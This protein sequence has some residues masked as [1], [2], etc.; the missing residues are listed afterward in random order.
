M[1][2]IKTVSDL[3]DL[4]MA[5]MVEVGKEIGRS[6]GFSLDL[7]ERGPMKLNNRRLP[8]NSYVVA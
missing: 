8:S 2:G 4:H 3:I 1:N 7:H 5:D 6:K